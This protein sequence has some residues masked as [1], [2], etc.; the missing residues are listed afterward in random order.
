MVFAA[1]AVLIVGGWIDAKGAVG[2]VDW[3][4]LV[5]M[6]SALGLSRA[7]VNSGLARLVGLA[8]RHLGSG[9]WT[10]LLL[11]LGW[12]TVRWRAKCLKEGRQYDGR[13]VSRVE[14][15]VLPR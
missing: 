4:V 12:T 7:I 6:G 9:R 10:S 1:V 3:A 13:R 15:P 8:V 11:L 5:L 14:C 2:H